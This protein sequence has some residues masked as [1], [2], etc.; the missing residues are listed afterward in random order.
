M[1]SHVYMNCFKTW[2]WHTKPW[3]FLQ[4]INFVIPE[5]FSV[6]RTISE[7]QAAFL[8]D[9]YVWLSLTLLYWH[10]STQSWELQRMN[11]SH[12]ALRNAGL[13]LWQLQHTFSSKGWHLINQESWDRVMCKTSH[14]CIF[15]KVWKS[16]KICEI[17]LND[18]SWGGDGLSGVE[19]HVFTWEL[20]P[21]YMEPLTSWVLRTAIKLCY[22]TSNDP[23]LIY[24]HYLAIKSLCQP[25]N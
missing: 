23:I 6:Q 11:V 4:P 2:F 10:P 17:W 20:N 14:F 1:F 21:L 7:N 8:T 25:H 9:L 13:T 22:I 3:F 12:P 16:N 19:W 24:C 18:C 5:L 15:W